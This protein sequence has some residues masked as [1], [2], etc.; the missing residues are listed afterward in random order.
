MIGIGRYCSAQPPSFLQIGLNPMG[1]IFRWAEGA[2]IK[3]NP[4]AAAEELINIE[5]KNNGV[6]TPAAVVN[7]ARAFAS[8]L[9]DHFEWDDNIAAEHY[10]SQQAYQLI[11]NIRVLI[12][13][14]NST[15]LEQPK[16]IYVNETSSGGYV[17]VSS[18]AGDPDRRDHILEQAMTRLESWQ[19][20]YTDLSS[21]FSTLFEEID[22]ALKFSGR[23]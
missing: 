17:R 9:H 4:Q 21:S 22:R 12:R 13:P 11:L 19:N 3:V 20:R 7:A 15:D 8:P 1:N 16:R 6:L 2:R 5:T 10:R 14:A 23:R 18:M